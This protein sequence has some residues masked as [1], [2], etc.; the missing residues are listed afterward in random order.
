MFK[1]L[2]DERGFTNLIIGVV[3]L[4][5]AIILYT[6]V[7]LP[8]IVNTNKAGTFTCGTYSNTTCGDA[9]PVATVAMYGILPVALIGGL[10]AMVIG[11]KM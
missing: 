10:I 6:S 2:K 3:G 1:F 5:I 7:V 11:S 8:I 4:V 9:W